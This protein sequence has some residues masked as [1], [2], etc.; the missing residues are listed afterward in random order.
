MVR[1]VGP[2]DERPLD[3]A[4]LVAQRDL[5]VKDVLAVA[6]EA[7]MSRLDDAG[8]HGPDGDLVDLVALNAK[9]SSRGCAWRQRRRAIRRGSES[10]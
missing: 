3:A 1:L 10:A 8:M 5:Q 6:L 7:E 2:A 9:E 4:M